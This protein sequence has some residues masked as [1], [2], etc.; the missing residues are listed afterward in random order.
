MTTLLTGA[1]GLVGANLAHLLCSRGE[2]PRLLVRERSDRRG[3][4]GLVQGRD[5]EEARGDILDAASLREAMRGVTHVYHAA[6]SV[7]FDPFSRQDLVRT[8]TEGAR[9]VLEA[10]R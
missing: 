5:Y 2:K 4:R 9:N 1:T 6:G 3:L 7:R 10:A 8:N